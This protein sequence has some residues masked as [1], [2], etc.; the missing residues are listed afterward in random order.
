LLGVFTLWALL[1]IRVSYLSLLPRFMILV[2]SMPFSILLGHLLSHDYIWAWTPKSIALVADVVLMRQL[3]TVGLVGSMGFVSG[4]YW[5]MLWRSSLNRLQRT[6]PQGKAAHTRTLDLPWYYILLTISLFFSYLSAPKDT[7]FQISY[8]G[9]ELLNT[10]ATALNF[11]ASYVVSYII[12]VVLFLDVQREWNVTR[13]KRKRFSL[14]ATTLYIIIF[15][16]LLRGDRESSGLIVALAALYLT[17]PIRQVAFIFWKQIIINRLNRL[18]IPTGIVVTIFILLASARVTLSD[19]GSAFN[20]L[21]ALQAGWS[22][23]P[24]TMTL[25]TNLGVASLYRDGTLDYRY[26]QTYFDYM[27]SLPP[28]VLTQLFGYERRLEAW[29]N[30]GVDVWNTGITSGGL[31]IALVP[32]MNF[33]ILGVFFFLALYGAVIAYLELIS[34]RETFW[35]KLLWA[36]T[37]VIGFIWFWYTDMSMIRGMM[38]ALLVGFLYKA[39]LPYRLSSVR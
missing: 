39:I 36:S 23:S 18:V 16:Q 8:G 34:Q 19:A 3:T 9:E 27:L 7:I 14:G 4:M 5:I 13:K 38:A 2:Y 6:L 11:N 22:T 33:G 32:F 21:D 35:P 15:L 30:P 37:F 12:L 10:L 26:G 20:I 31:H 25:F 1:K 17:S 29:N 28:G 24:W